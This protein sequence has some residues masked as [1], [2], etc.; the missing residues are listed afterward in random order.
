MACA[1]LVV[2]KRGRYLG[3]DAMRVR[4]AG[5]QFGFRLDPTGI[6]RLK[7]SL[8]SRKINL[9]FEEH[10]VE[11]EA[12][13]VR[14][15]RRNSTHTLTLPTVG[16]GLDP[17]FWWSFRLKSHV[18]VLV[19]I[20][21]VGTTLRI[22]RHSRTSTDLH[23]DLTRDPR[24]RIELQAG[25][26][27]ALDV[28]GEQ[29]PFTVVFRLVRPLGHQLIL[30]FLRAEDGV[31][32]TLEGS[33]PLEGSFIV[34]PY[35]H[36]T[37]KLAGHGS[38]NRFV[39]ETALAIG[40][41]FPPGFLL[42]V[43][44]MPTGF[45]DFP[46]STNPIEGAPRSSFPLLLWTDG[47][48]F[49]RPAAGPISDSVV[50]RAIEKI[51]FFGNVTASLVQ[52]ELERPVLALAVVTRSSEVLAKALPPPLSLKV[53]DS[54]GV[55]QRFD[56]AG[57][58]ILG[59]VVPDYAAQWEALDALAIEMLPLGND[60]PSGL[61]ALWREQM[62]GR[63]KALPYCLDAAVAMV[64]SHI[65]R[66]RG[67]A[68][69]D[70]G[71]QELDYKALFEPDLWLCPW[72]AEDIDRSIFLLEIA[73]RGVA[74]FLACKVYAL[75][76]P[77][78]RPSAPP[79][80]DAR[81][82]TLEMIAMDLVKRWARG[83]QDTSPAAFEAFETCIWNT[84]AGPRRVL[85]ALALG[86]LEVFHEKL[87]SAGNGQTSWINPL[88]LVVSEASSSCTHDQ[89]GF[90][91][92]QSIDISSAYWTIYAGAFS[93]D[94]PSAIIPT[95]LAP[96]S[97]SPAYD[98]QRELRLL[99]HSL[100]V[101]SAAAKTRNSILRVRRDLGDAV[102]SRLETS[103]LQILRAAG[104]DRIVAISPV[105]IDFVP[106]GGTILGLEI[107]LTRLPADDPRLTYRMINMAVMSSI[108]TGRCEG[109]ASVFGPLA[110]HDDAETWAVQMHEVIVSLLPLLGLSRI[111]IE[112]REGSL[113]ESIEAAELVFFVGHAAASEDRGGINL[114]SHWVDGRALS[115][116]EWTGKLAFL[117]GCE[118]A[119]LDTQRGD[120]AKLL[121]ERG[122]RAVIGTTA[123]IEIG[124][125]ETF[126]RSFL[127]EAMRGA[128]IETA[129]HLARRCAVLA[130]ALQARG[131]PWSEAE[132]RAAAA[133][134]HANPLISFHD[135]LAQEGFTWEQT[136]HDAVYSLSLT[137]VGGST[138]RLR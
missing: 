105:L 111:D 134:A 107:P 114:G 122:A 89:S 128:E 118:T 46:I 3:L 90:G 102:S 50:G 21:P 127:V 28:R 97:L 34:S 65:N 60:I 42:P 112:A 19:D 64:L 98:L 125:A 96:G 66:Q 51:V 120:L 5:D 36:R 87:Q 52:T 6:P 104:A 82:D 129:F 93:T 44:S 43:S 37:F 133:I 116:L 109:F 41:G 91:Y 25:D 131:H 32:L 86:F 10:S 45:G 61:L 38:S 77:Q 124:V 75:W 13:K 136:Y 126:L 81:D 15:E 79:P 130:E 76:A 22:V 73:L 9:P 2:S 24:H 117:I 106:F 56:C 31:R 59:L 23:I 27:F 4:S 71:S 95:L 17:W 84:G 14:F 7:G 18:R 78:G 20:A 57:I 1:D 119:A 40:P 54:P 138:G 92:D 70:S 69:P 39:S 137:L 115:K 132:R 94:K 35:A 110:A 29:Y 53:T 16:S 62:Q 58:P 80:P 74:E 8:A 26:S 83:E 101:K 67:R 63:L 55:I 68:M 135:L 108:A 113:L 103:S 47:A 121:I 100:D 30:N 99:F 49:L 123:K 11:A 33:F 12:V 48:T 85:A 88:V 72:P